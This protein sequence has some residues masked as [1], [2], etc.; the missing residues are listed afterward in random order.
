MTPEHGS[1]MFR[2]PERRE[3][4]D[5][6]FR[7]SSDELAKVPQGYKLKI[8]CRICLKLH[9]LKL[10]EGWVARTPAGH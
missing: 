6:G 5:S 8:R 2:C 3:E 1:L 4:F 9:E 10:S 7:F